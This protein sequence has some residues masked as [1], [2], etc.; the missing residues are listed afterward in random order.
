MSEQRKCRTCGADI[1]SNA[2]FGHCPHCLLELG[3][4]P[5]PRASP[6]HSGEPTPQVAPGIVRYFGDYE[7]LEEIGRGGMGVVYKARQIS[8][9]RLVA[10]KM[11]RSGELASPRAVQRF[12]LEAE[13]AA[14]LDHPNIVPIYEIGVHQ[15]QHYFSMKLIQGSTLAEAMAGLHP[16]QHQSAEA[17]PLQ[18]SL[19][20]LVRWMATIARTVHFAHQH[21]ILHRDL[22]PGNILIDARREP[23]VSDFGLAKMLE[24][25]VGVS[26]S[27]DILGTP[28]YMS[29]EQAAGRTASTAADTWSLGVILYELLTGRLPFRADHTPALLR[30]IA[31]DEP[32]PFNRGELRWKNTWRGVDPRV[33]RPLSD[34]HSIDRDLETVCL[35]CLEKDPSRRYGSAAALADDLDRW[36][37]FEPI[38]ARPT[39]LLGRTWR[40]C[41]RQPVVASLLAV[42]ALLLVSVTVA[43]T[44]SARHAGE[45][46]DAERRGRIQAETARTNELRL[47]AQAEANEKL[48]R[49]EFDKSVQVSTFLKEMLE[50]V[51]PSVARGRDT[52]LMREILD[53][54]SLRLGH[55]LSTQ[56]E[57]EALLRRTLGQV[58]F[59]LGAVSNAE[60]MDRRAV[61]LYRNLRGN[62]HSDVAAALGSLAIRLEHLGRL[63]E[64]EAMCREVLAMEQKL[65]GD[66]RPDVAEALVN[67]AAILKARGKLTE[68]EATARK[69]LEL[70]RRWAGT[71]DV[72]LAAA[73]NCLGLLLH[74]RGRQTE[75]EKLLREAL[76]LRKR[77]RGE[78][79]PEVATTLNN[80][81]L[82]LER[83]S[84]FAEAEPLHRES[85][86]LRRKLYGP[87]HP[88][89]AVA[90]NNLALVL[91]RQEKLADAE[92][93]IRAALVIQRQR[94]SSDHPDISWSLSSLG[95][96]LLA[97][98]KLT[99]AEAS[100]REALVQRRKVLGNTH[101]RVAITRDGLA[102]VLERQAKWPE[103][104][105]L[106]REALEVARGRSRTN[107]W[108]LSEPLIRLATVLLKREKFAE[109]EPV[110][111]EA[112]ELGE[113]LKPESARLLVAKT[114]LGAAHL[115]Q[116]QLD[117]AEP[118]L[119]ATCDLMRARE[120]EFSADEIMH[121]L[122]SLQRLYEAKGD[123]ERAARWAEERRRRS[124]AKR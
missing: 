90:L 62:E 68:A 83:Q 59:A 21:G 119:V 16:T 12:H 120:K 104:E 96:L 87:D 25:E 42:I 53:K 121:G 76:A 5:A 61:E 1:P 107:D 63:E 98:G 102:T 93:L 66:E 54:T 34:R 70:E 110:A 35:K 2:P 3:F 30:K 58:Y 124:A 41:R 92:P 115:G 39:S 7:L 45:A 52:Q 82:T 47:R 10:L 80:L 50:G 94:L 65:G 69:G 89:V 19:T 27:A 75:A 123:P 43:A 51:G 6:E 74:E 86:A 46:R 55:D 100:F 26:R 29:P 73:L 97:E 14:K 109:T 32:A 44:I 67:L 48:A 116:R 57:V 23:I 24:H 11:I 4:G 33:G 37:N 103:A 60:A 105:T 108:E 81:A 113:K 49:S 122:E 85:L 78:D 56:P 88:N 114:L 17:T 117:Q 111:R 9:Q 79:H 22:K 8:L 84:K 31:E 18:W 71:N 15:G 101:P 77:A 72:Q 36:L 38:H 13:A 99:E 20:T 106:R 28:S 40:W 64:S 112:V 118:L 91:R 95:Q